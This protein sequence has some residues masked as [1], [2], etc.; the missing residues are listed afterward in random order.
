MCCGA[1]AHRLFGP[2]GWNIPYTF[3]ENDLRISMRQL[4]MFLDEFP[5]LPLDMLKYTAG[6]CNYGGTV[7]LA[8]PLLELTAEGR[9]ARYGWLVMHWSSQQGER[10]KL[11]L[12]GPAVELTP[13]GPLASKTSSHAP[14][15][16][17]RHRQ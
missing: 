14:G 17:S 9:G 8:G 7:R 2:V 10:D 6:E 3:N 15:S 1:L 11:Q 16:V 13:R 12:A 4:R 5:V